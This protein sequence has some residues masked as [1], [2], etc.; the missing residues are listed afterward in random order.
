M[1]PARSPDSR[2]RFVSPCV[3]LALVSVGLA[4]AISGVYAN[5][6]VWAGD[7]EGRADCG[8]AWEPNAV[9]SACAA[10]LVE[11]SWVAV[12]LLGAA[13]FGALGAVVVVGRSPRG[14]GRQLVALAATI[15][16]VVIAAGLLW[17]GVI[18][19]TAGT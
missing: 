13:L 1:L 5:A 10:A 9:T 17:G 14:F 8:T 4:I 6:T 3:V 15:G 19:R 11:R 12:A 2:R 18:D 16:V 7:T